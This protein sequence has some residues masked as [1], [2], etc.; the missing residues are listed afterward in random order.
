MHMHLKFDIK[1]AL[2]RMGGNFRIFVDFVGPTQTMKN[3]IKIYIDPRKYNFL[4]LETTN[5]SLFHIMHI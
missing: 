4:G 3:S 1:R 2:Y 5:L